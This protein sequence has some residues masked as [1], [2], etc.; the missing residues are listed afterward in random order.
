MEVE[1]TL[2]G[3]IRCHN[4]KAAMLST[5]EIIHRRLANQQISKS[6]F[7]SPGEIVRWFG[8]MQSQDW[9][10][11]KWALGLRLPGSIER[12]IERAFNEGNIL[13]THVL[14]PTW[15]FLHPNDIKWILK[16]SAP[17][18][19]MANGL[20]YRKFDI[21]PSLIKKTNAI[22]GKI[23]RDKNFL[24]RE[25]LNIEFLR[26]KIKT[27]RMR[28]VY[29]IM[30]AELEG[31]ICSGPRRGKQ[32]TYA[33]VE[34]RAPQAKVMSKQESLHELASRYF[35]SRGPATVKDFAW[36]SG[37][38]VRDCHEAIQ[39]LG[40]PFVKSG[41]NEQVF[42]FN[43]N[44]PV[45]PL[46]NATFLA[47]DYDEYAIGYKDRTMYHHPKWH[48]SQKL[49]HPEYFHAVVVDGCFG[50]N[51][52]RSLNGK[53]VNIETNLYS[54]L[55]QKHLNQVNKAVRLYRN[56]FEIK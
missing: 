20:Y 17:R 21:E 32:F 30:H 22:L 12:D 15:H 49:E 40:A 1:V 11:A 31:L 55:T 43:E 14:R 19:H 42:I 52:K 36:W 3:I 37:L 54:S 18:V 34:E 7:S 51:W 38:T 44:M 4:F 35:T 50:G 46:S 9:N 27:D 56:F 39:S 29:I 16:L 33:L 41:W 48:L 53:K 23:L 45:A 28:L 26:G 10:M 6:N 2:P 13:R 24:T 25:E 47:P 5:K 8:A